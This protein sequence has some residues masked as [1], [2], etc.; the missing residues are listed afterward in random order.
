MPRWS[1]HDLQRYLERGA[2]AANVVDAAAAEEEA[3]LHQDILDECARRGWICDHGS[4][5]HR[6]KRKRG[7]QDFT[8]LVDGGRFLL[9]EAKSRRGKLSPEQ[10]EF[11][12]EELVGKCFDISVIH[13]ES[14]D[15]RIFDQIALCRP[16]KGEKIEPSSDYVRVRDRKEGKGR[17]R[18]EKDDDDGD[19]G[20]G[21]SEPS[22]ES[23]FRRAE[24]ASKTKDPSDH[25]LIKV[26]VGKHKGLELRD[27]TREAIEKLIEGWLTKVFPEIEKPLA[28]DRR[29]AA[30]LE[31]YRKKFSGEPDEEDPD[32]VPY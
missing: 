26:H 25:G 19:G 11:E 13:E 16:W 9:V 15:G 21:S 1:T 10:K 8:I 5:A 20:E 4:M 29:L 22:K 7:E 30:A 14:E 23:T 18:S 6:T 32:D 31:A 12:T 28:D 3:Q 2:A 24:Q 17:R 27:L